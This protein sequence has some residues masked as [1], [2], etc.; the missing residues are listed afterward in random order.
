MN[1][2]QQEIEDM[3]HFVKEFYCKYEYI[4]QADGIVKLKAACKK[5]SKVI[6]CA[7]KPTRVTSNFNSHVK[8][9]WLDYV[10]N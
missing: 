6:Q 10:L 8:V 2:N 4:T 1:S 5:C 9:S 3:P 7:W